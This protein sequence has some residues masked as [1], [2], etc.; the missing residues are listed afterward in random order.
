MANLSVDVLRGGLVESVHRV[1]AAVVDSNGRLIA[2]AG[3][4][5]LLTYWRSAAK[6]FQALPLVEDGVLTHFKLGA[7]ALALAC[8]SHSSEPRHLELTDRMLEAIGC[9][10]ADL[11]CGPHPPLNPE[12]AQ[13]VNREGIHLTA[14]WSNCSGKHAGMLAL[15]RHHGWE[16]RGY[17]RAGHPVQ[18]R[19]LDEVLRWTGLDRERLV[20]AVDGCTT[21]CFGL[22]VAAMA[23]SY[24]ALASGETAGLRQVR[25]AMLA[26]PELVAGEGRFC[27]E[28]MRAMPGV[29]IAKV[30]AEGIH[31]AA[32]PGVGVGI[33]LKVED[34]DMRA[35]PPALLFVLDQLTEQVADMPRDGTD[36]LREWRRAPL[37]STRQVPV[38]E[39][40][41]TGSLQFFAA[42]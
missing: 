26:H 25:E 15:A 4:P 40:H 32:L 42:G 38:G 1:S 16:T 21:V 24:A 10:E 35:S 6:P 8:A 3:N 9:T 33:A 12:V 5:D 30:G 34:G 39:T 31:C 14:R 17:E 37:L 28:I 23:R 7:D 36:T 20:Q 41:A 2:A 27:T 11:A 29:V 19:I 13:R 22:S 18:E